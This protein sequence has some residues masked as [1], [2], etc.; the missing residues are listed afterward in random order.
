MIKLI[1]SKLCTDTFWTPEYSVTASTFQTYA[2][3][4]LKSEP[5]EG[6]LSPKGNREV[7]TYNV[8][9]LNSK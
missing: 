3:L 1:N 7:M 5:D 4:L 9:H 6:F 8:K 2:A